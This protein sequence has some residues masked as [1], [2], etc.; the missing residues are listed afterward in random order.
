[1]MRGR[2]PHHRRAAGEPP[3]VAETFKPEPLVPRDHVAG[4]AERIDSDGDVRGRA[5]R[6]GGRARRSTRSSPTGVDAVAIAFLWSVRNAAHERRAREII[7]ERAPDAFVTVSHEISKSVGEY[8]RFVATADQRLRRPGHQHATSRVARPA[9]GPRLRRRA[10]YSCSATAAWSR[11][12]TAPTARSS[13]SA[14]GPVGGLV[15]CAAPRRRPRPPRH[16]RHRHGRHQ[17]DVGIIKDGEPLAADDTAARQ[18]ALPRAGGRGDLDRRRR[19]LDRLG[20]P[21]GGGLRVGPQSASSNPGPACYGRGGEEPTVTDANLVLGYVAPE[22]TF[23]TTATRRLDPPRRDLAEAA[24]ARGSPS[25]SG[26]PSTDAA[27]GIVE[28]ANAKMANAARERGHRPRLR[29]A[30]LPPVSYGGSGPLHAAGYA[31]AARHRHGSSIPG[32]A[33]SVWSAFGI[34]QSDVRYQSERGRRCSRP[35]TRRDVRGAFEELEAQPLEAARRARGRRAPSS[36]A[37]TRAC[38]TSGSATSS[39]SSFPPASSTP[40][41]STAAN[42]DFVERYGERYG[43][44]ALLPGARLEIVSM[45]LE[46]AIPVGAPRTSTASTVPS[47]AGVEKGTRAGRLRARR[48]RRRRRRLRRRRHAARRRSSRAPP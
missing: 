44:A 30:R 43:E 1:M 20:R 27:L 11:C 34:A 14:P 33:A 35:S 13:R 40:P 23:G 32:E 10:A 39:R 38:A 36:S 3:Q 37:A 15:G 6:G 26:C 48:R 25:R 41:P 46:P 17:F 29:P 8:E 31:R 28:I 12:G 2:R 24:I 19:R 22:A 47:D 18:V 7:S 5:R 45:R 21:L 16:H 4:I 42:A 9:R